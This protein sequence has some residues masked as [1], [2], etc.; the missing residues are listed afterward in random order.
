MKKRITFSIIIF[1][2]FFA[3]GTAFKVRAGVSQSARG[4]LWGG[5]EDLDMCDSDGNGTVDVAGCSMGGTA[6]GDN[7]TGVEK[8]S[9]NNE[10]SGGSIDYGV[11]IPQANGVV[12]GYA[13]SENIGWIDF[14]DNCV[15]DN[16]ADDS[17]LIAGQCTPRDATKYCSASCAAP[18]GC[19]KGVSRSGNNLEG[20]ARIVDIAKESVA[21]NSGGWKGW[22]K[23]NGPNYQ[24]QINTLAN[25]AKIIGCTDASVTP[26][27]CAWNGENNN[28]PAVVHNTANGFGWF[29]LSRVTIIKPK[30]LKICDGSCGGNSPIANPVTLDQQGSNSKKENIKACYN[31]NDGCGDSNGDVTSLV[32]SW[33]IAD[34]SIVKKD[35][36][37]NQYAIV[38]IKTGAQ[39]PNST[40]ITAK[41]TD[42]TDGIVPSKDFNVR[43]NALGCVPMDCD[44]PASLANRTLVCKGDMAKDG[45]NCG[46]TCEG[47]KD[48]T[49]WRE[50][51]NE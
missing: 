34:T 45:N 28:D 48:C 16:S 24:I 14:G 49:G 20:C 33:D 39:V 38:A 4:W 51:G 8:I 9:S 7:E 40:V 22:I 41:Y 44:L 47:T 32:S 12:T 46:Y 37:A 18:A 50:I 25:P 26:R 10:T 6:E 19:T 29:D 35:P 5:S 30:T 17:D 23:M 15:E 21:G 27:S 1:L 36:S 13:W 2:I 3:L 31:D 11:S 43:I 42:P